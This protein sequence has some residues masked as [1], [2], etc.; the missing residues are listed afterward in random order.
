VRKDTGNRSSATLEVPL[1]KS[2][3]LT[4]RGS[5][6]S[7]SVN[8]DCVAR[9]IPEPNDPGNITIIRLND[10]NEIAAQE[11]PAEVIKK[12]IIA[13]H[14]YSKRG[15]GQAYQRVGYGTRRLLLQ[16]AARDHIERSIKEGFFCEV[17]A[18]SE[19]IISD[20][21]ESRLSW[22]A[23]DF[24]DQGNDTGPNYQ[25]A[26]GFWELGRLIKWLRVCETDSKLR[27]LLDAL[28]NWRK[29]R[30]GALHEMV[31]VAA[32]GPVPDWKTQPS[33]WQRRLDKLAKSACVGYELVKRLY[34]QVADLNP[35]H[36]DR[37][38]PY[39]ECSGPN[40]EPDASPDPAGV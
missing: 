39:P 27:E 19:S 37:V 35:W 10:G 15:R 8:P 11:K 33:D 14:G 20:R 34:H 7:V 3:H 5:N 29:E 32:D 21:L 28:D 30:N 25:Y 36:H 4:D 18:I 12:L 1:A 17:I 40:A 9:V 22:L 2:I 26:I 13:R 38:F 16:A 23:K 24:P 31:K 6:S